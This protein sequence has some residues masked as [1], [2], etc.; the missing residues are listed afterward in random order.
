VV[1]ICG[2]SVVI[3]R[4]RGA[5]GVHKIPFMFERLVDFFNDEDTRGVP[6]FASA[7]VGIEIP[8]KAESW[9]FPPSTT[10]RFG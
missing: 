2:G 6:S 9:V 8:E 3:E 7:M 5:Y 1:C 4:E 10:I